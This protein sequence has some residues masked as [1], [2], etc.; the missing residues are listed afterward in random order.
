M[1]DE[2]MDGCGD[3]DEHDSAYNAVYI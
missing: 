2:W 1:D 3:D